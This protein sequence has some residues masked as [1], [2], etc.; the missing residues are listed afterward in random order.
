MKFKQLKEITKQRKLL[1][2]LL[3]E[4]EEQ[5]KQLKIQEAYLN[6]LFESAPEAI[7]ILDEN[8]R[9]RRVNKEFTKIFGYTKEE[10][11]NHQINDLIVP[12]EFKEHGS[13]LTNKAAKGGRVSTEA[14]RQHKNGTLIHVSILATPIKVEDGQVAV[15][16]IYRDITD[17]KKAD[18][19]LR[20]EK[21]LFQMLFDNLP[22]KIFFKDSQHRFVRVNRT[23]AQEQNVTP[24]EMIGKTD[25]DYFPKEIA[26]N[27]L[28]DDEYILKTGKSI[29][30][31][32]EV[33]YEGEGGRRWVAVTKLP[34]RNELGEIIGTMGIA[35]DITQRKLTEETLKE[36]EERY[37]SLFNRVPVGLYRT[38]PS[39]EIL[40]ANDALVELLHYENKEALMKDNAKNQYIDPDARKQW[41]E[42][43]LKRG[44]LRNYESQTR[45]ADNQIIWLK[46][47]ARVVKDEKGDV[48]YYEGSFE[49]ITE[50]KRAEEE[51][52]RAKEEAEKANREL[53]QL[54]EHLEQ[55]TLFAKE[56]ALQAEM[57]SAAKSEFLA[58]MSHEIR[59]PMNG[60]LG[61][62]ELTLETDLTSEQCEYLEMVKSSA[63][64]LLTI[65]NDILDFSKIEAGKLEIESIPF[66]L[67]DTVGDT[68]NTLAIK[69]T[70]KNLELTS[71]ISP[72]VPIHVL[73]DP[74]RVRQILLNLIGNAIKFTE[75]GEVV[76]YVTKEKFITQATHSE[77]ND[78]VIELKFAV[79]DTGEGIP[80]E[81]Q[82]TIFE[83]FMQADGSTTRK[84]GGTGL[85]LAI[86]SQLVKIMGG[87][88][89]VESPVSNAI[90]DA[91]AH[92]DM[93]LN[94]QKGENKIGGPGSAFYFTIRFAIQEKSKQ[95]PKRKRISSMEGLPVLVADDNSTNL[96]ILEKMLINWGLKPS[97]VSDGYSA[98][99][100]LNKESENGNSFSLVLIDCQM[101]GMDGFTLA[102]KILENPDFRNLPI[103]MLT[104][105][106][107]RG[108]AQRCREIGIAAYLTKPVKQSKLYDAIVTVLGH[109]GE[110][111][112]SHN[113]LITRHI[114]RE[115]CSTLNIL[116]AEDNP[117]NQKVT[118][119]LLEKMGHHPIIV[120]DGKKA[121]DY[122]VQK[123]DN[124][125]IDLIL[126]DVQMPEMNG[127][128]ATEKIR[129]YESNNGNGHHI[130]IIAITAHAM[131]DDE[132]K[133]LAAGMDGY[134]SKPVKVEKL[135]EYL[136]RYFDYKSYSAENNA[137]DEL[138]DSQKIL[139]K[140]ELMRRVD[141]DLELLKELTDTL[142]ENKDQWLADIKLAAKQDS[143]P[144]LEKSAHTLKGAVSNFGAPTV[145]ETVSKLEAFAKDKK[146]REALSLITVLEQKIEMLVMELKRCLNKESLCEY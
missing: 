131:K 14:I 17:Q 134:L 122:W 97:T 80:G 28:K 60:I 137:G 140:S 55:T 129:E 125:E 128:E 3:K 54:N 43:L 58:N 116:V 29:V 11:L 111:H 101:P 73:G 69:A 65:I 42:K 1:D 91:Q 22:D 71:Y 33:I 83:A 5:Q 25:F 124:N 68:L 115:N 119:H 31:K 51:L 93:N 30:E 52:K 12:T 99:E 47:N 10:A 61:M 103:M 146:F 141:N 133:C 9:C 46:E 41:S 105:A 78:P 59:T 27:S 130:P 79:I 132:E 127:F 123:S 104:S 87:K 56:M 98:L 32:E 135:E 37:R 23:K 126:M 64:S 88:I 81:K 112:E 26:E 107:Q 108:D 34:R 86:S 66:N 53:L 38:T 36:S 6:E 85:G 49:D 106:G 75:E 4:N 89:W 8:D 13:Y 74:G 57:A 113:Q 44:T 96:H 109:S 144:D 7:V 72:E 121:V 45:C 24:E 118:R 40:E 15:Y 145:Y 48:L 143:A 114:L 138:N 110:P 142:V 92:S 70:Q 2:S 90:T 94:S 95:P 100:L 39:G 18:E 21:N 77:K 136:Y 67:H 76:V 20:K 117:V 35:S 139:D 62:T 120:D 102:Q 63:N 16:G 19:A 84:F 50:R 82:K